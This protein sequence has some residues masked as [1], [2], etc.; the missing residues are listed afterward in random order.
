MAR[1]MEE[2][3]ALFPTD[4]TLNKDRQYCEELKSG[5]NELEACT[6]NTN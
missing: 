3:G 2:H 1:D 6:V 4:G 5:N